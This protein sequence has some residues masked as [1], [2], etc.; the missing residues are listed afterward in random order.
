MSRDLQKVLDAKRRYREKNKDRISEYNKSYYRTNK[1]KIN[2]RSCE[3][4][5]S[6][7]EKILEYNK[8]YWKEN[9]E[10]LNARYKEYYQACKRTILSQ[11]KEYRITNGVRIRDKKR[12][13]DAT[14]EATSAKH[15]RRIENWRS[16]LISS[17]RGSAKRRNIDF[18]ISEDDI[19][20]PAKS[21]CPIFGTAFEI[22]SG[23]IA[24][25]SATID[26]IDNTKGYVP[27]NI[28]VI[29]ALA[30]RIKHESD[31]ALIYRLG[32][33]LKEK[34][35]NTGS[36]ID[37]NE[38]TRLMRH[39]MV[40]YR[41]YQNKRHNNLEF[42]IQWFDL[43][44]TECCPCTG[45]KLDYH[46]ANKDWRNFA[47]IDRIDNTKGYIPGNV[48]VISALANVMKTTATSFQILRVAEVL[49]FQMD[50]SRV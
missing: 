36:G 5:I 19:A 6:N 25:H 26:R 28:W 10:W 37:T 13:Y 7:K 2:K 48:W 41:K 1:P 49:K 42:S 24:D 14:Y 35:I 44:L 43:S 50:Q 18:L 22:G 17:A 12:S 9:K 21:F 40:K 20:D 33:A 39:N 15:E 46:N 4:K 30:N 31:A 34:E 29:S 16:Y 27:G 11:K 32:I 23:S 8:L 47:T 38:E 45:V 3:Y